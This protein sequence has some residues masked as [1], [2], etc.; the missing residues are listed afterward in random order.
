LA[1]FTVTE[2]ATGNHWSFGGYDSFGVAGGGDPDGAFE[3]DSWDYFAMQTAGTSTSDDFDWII[4]NFTVEVIGS[5]ASLLGDYNNDGSVDAAD[6]VVWRK[7]GINGQQG[8]NDWRT[9]F[10]RTT[11][12][13]GA[14]TSAAVPEPASIACLWVAGLLVLSRRWRQRST[15]NE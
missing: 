15:M 2:R 10:G 9:N 13:G 7:N 5:N 11:G 1:R 8:Y 6:Y 12:S 4:D 3:S 14:L